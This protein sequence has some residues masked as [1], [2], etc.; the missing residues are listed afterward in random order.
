MS[1][2]SKNDGGKER[3]LSLEWKGKIKID[4]A[5][6]VNFI[7]FI[8]LFIC[9]FVCLFVCLFDYLMVHMMSNNITGHN[10]AIMLLTDKNSTKIKQ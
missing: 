7:I 8:Y 6:D 4:A 3:V 9:L 1:G 5:D 10:K 2:C